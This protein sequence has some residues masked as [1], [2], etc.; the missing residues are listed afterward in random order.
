VRGLGRRLTPRARIALV[1]VA[2]LAVAALGYLT[3]IAPKRS[4]ASELDSEVASVEARIDEYRAATPAKEAKAAAKTAELFKLAK[5][6]PDDTD[7][8]GVILELNEIAAAS[9]IV[10]DAITP[11]ARTAQKGYDVVPIT[12]VFRGNFYSLSDF[13]YRVRNLVSVRNRRLAARGRLFAVAAVKFG[14]DEKTR[15]PNIKAELTVNAF[16][17]GGGAPA[18]APTESPADSG[19]TTT[20]TTT[21][22][23]TTT[24]PSE[25]PTNTAPSASAAAPGS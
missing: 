5:A 23:S 1:L 25:A 12:V 22:T 24:A 17:F 19:D 11:G 21:E 13:L 4:T 16:I 10:F 18:A 3:A 14:E 15:F 2:L 8:S 7:M 20:T 9:G 6:M